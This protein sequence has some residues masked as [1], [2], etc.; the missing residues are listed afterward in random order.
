MLNSLVCISSAKFFMSHP[1]AQWQLHPIERFD[2]FAEAWDRINDAGTGLP[3]L[4]SLFI[5]HLLR[6]FRSGTECLVV[7]GPPGEEQALGIVRSSRLG[8]WETYQ[9]SQLPL[10]A[11]VMAGSLD[12]AEVAASLLRT[13]PGTPLLFALTQ[14]DPLV[15]PR[16]SNSAT[17]RTFDWIQTGWVEVDGSFDA[18]WKAR[19]KQLQQNMRTQRSKLKSHGIV[20]VLEVLTRAEDIAGAIEDYGRLE[21]AGW[22]AEQGTAVRADNDQGRFYRAMLEDFCRMDAARVYR[23][24]FG[25]RVVAVDLCIESASVHVLLKTTYDES[26]RGLSPSSLLRQDA[27]RHVFEEGRVRSIEFY[28][29]VMDWTRRWTDRKR[30]LYHINS[31]RWEFVATAAARFAELRGTLLTDSA[32]PAAS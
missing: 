20:P 23:Y 11:W 4:S 25:D 13:L 7:L 28:G 27:Y 3:F 9:P 24:R 29:R 19:G 12:Y 5:R 16:P 14:Q 30:T 17:L 2:D 10:G 6:V 8:A 31:Y 22:K 15:K 1:H 18:Y 26:I 32:V 21:G